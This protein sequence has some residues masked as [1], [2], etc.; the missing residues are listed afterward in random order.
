MRSVIVASSEPPQATSNSA[1]DKGTFDTDPVFQSQPVLKHGAA[2]MSDPLINRS[3]LLAGLIFL[4]A[5]LA[6]CNTV[7]GAGQ[8]IKSVG[9]A[10]EHTADEAGDEIGE[11][12]GEID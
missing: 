8:D 3:L 9:N 1:V 12:A 7:E 6:A 10:V 5:P 4:G 11:E 2:E